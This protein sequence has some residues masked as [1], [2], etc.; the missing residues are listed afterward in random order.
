MIKRNVESLNPKFKIDVRNLTWP[1]YLE[2]MHAGKMPVFLMGAQ[3]TGSDPHGAMLFLLRSGGVMASAQ[4]LSDKKIDA[5]IDKAL[6]E[7]NV[8][9]RAALYREIQIADYES[10]WRLY[11]VYGKGLW[12]H[13]ADIKGFNSVFGDVELRLIYR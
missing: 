6:R 11:T 7:T 4:N 8:K 5:L 2:K 12:A 10:C 1:L 9:K 3:S 13:G